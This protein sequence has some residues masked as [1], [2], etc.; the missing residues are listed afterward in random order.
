MKMKIKYKRMNTRMEKYKNRMDPHRLAFQEASP[1]ATPYNIIYKA[2][3]LPQQ[4]EKNSW[5]Q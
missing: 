5:P 2:N 4:D 3:W 1:S